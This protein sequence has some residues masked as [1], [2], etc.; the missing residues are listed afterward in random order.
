MLIGI[1]IPTV[2]LCQE[3]DE[4]WSVI[5]WQQRITSFVYYLENKFPLTGFTELKELNG[6]FFKDIWISLY[7]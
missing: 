6:L 3:N 2:Y 5:D 7:T 1:P 4:T